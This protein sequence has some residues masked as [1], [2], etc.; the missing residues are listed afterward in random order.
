MVIPV[1]ASKA[2]APIAAKPKA[3]VR[4]TSYAAP[5]LVERYRRAAYWLRTPQ[6]DLIETAL[7]AGVEKLEK[8][9][10]GQFKPVPGKAK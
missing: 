2:A 10:G 5:E 1:A 8:A 4:F 7:T 6:Y 3:R 9:N